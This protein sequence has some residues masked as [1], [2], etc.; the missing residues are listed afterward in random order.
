[1][2][3]STFAELQAEFLARV[4]KHVYAN[5]ATIDTKD[6]PRSRIVHP[7]WEGSTG[8]IISWP[9]TP[10]SKHLAHNPYVSLSY[11]QD[12]EKPVYVECIAEWKH[13]REEKLRVWEVIKATPPPMGF[14]PEPH[15]G[16]I[17][18]IHFGLLELTP[19][20]IEVFTLREEPIIWR[21]K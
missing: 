2:E 10:K 6:R 11:I 20:R 21:Q 5:M 9:D 13:E 16:T 19:W 14:D 3:V 17:D 1:M 18:H 8:W 15:F 4:G 7:I 12:F